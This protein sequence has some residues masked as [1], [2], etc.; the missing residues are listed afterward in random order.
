MEDL[1]RVFPRK[2][3]WTPTDEMAFIGDPPLFRPDAKEVH[4]SCTFTW[5]LPE[6]HRLQKAW[7]QYYS[8]VRIGGP[9]LDDPGGE[10]EPGLYIKNGV[11]VTS[12]GCIKKCSWCHV[13]RREGKIRELKIKPGWIIQDNNLLACSALHITEVFEMLSKL[14]KAA[15]FRGGLDA[16]LFN[17]WHK[18]L[19]ESIKVK[20][21]FFACD[22]K[23]ALKPLEKVANLL[24]EYSIN[25]KRCFVMIG[26][27]ETIKE[28]EKRLQE[29]YAFGFL[30][31]AQ[32]YQP[33]DKINYSKEWKAL[34]RKWSRPAAYRAIEAKYAGWRV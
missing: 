6:A 17:P 5:D 30:P 11:T 12:R 15:E 2:T 21:M 29:V 18:S 24:N 33:I 4:V 22:T 16:T 32:L 28:A 27:N 1:I 34:A 7:G 3:A 25:K 9:A 8:T 14:G 13:A 20:E 31:F 26:L 10:F 19:L 23:E